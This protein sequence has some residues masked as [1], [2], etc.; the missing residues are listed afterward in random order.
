MSIDSIYT[1]LQKTYGTRVKRDEPLA[2]YTTLKVGG[3]ADIFFAATDNDEIVDI[4]QRAAAA[5]VPYIVLGGGS[6]ILVADAGIRGIVIKNMA[7]HIG[8]RG[9]K[10]EVRGDTQTGSVFVEASSGAIINQLVRFTIEEGLQGLEM[11][12][13]L[14]GTV[15]GALYMNSKWTKPEG[16]VGDVVYQAKILG[17]DGQVRDEPKSYFKFAYDQSI[18]QQTHEIVLAVVFEL[19]KASKD[20]LWETANASISYRRETQPHGVFSPGCT[21]RNIS[22][23]DAIAIPTPG[24]TTSA[25]FLID[26][27]GLKGMKVGGAQISPVHA[28]F[29][30]NTGGATAADV[31]QLI[32]RARQTVKKQFGVTLEEEIVRLGEFK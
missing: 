15:G 11:H 28:N 17:A 23:A 10:G 21:F 16:Y 19:K 2:M 1:D 9:V 30:V 27:A 24:N 25:G 31:V 20:A 5:H 4:V 26:S 22:K 32:E 3:P 7:K 18:L 12:L 8:I 6:N 13:G 14:P 29:I